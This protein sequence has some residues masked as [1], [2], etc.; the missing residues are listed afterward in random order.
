MILRSSALAMLGMIVLT[1]TLH[2]QSAVPSQ[3]S[4]AFN[5]LNLNRNGNSPASNYFQ[6]VRPQFQN[7]NALMNVQQ[8]YNNLQQS[9][10]NGDNS[11]ITMRGTGHAATFMSYGHYYPRMGGGTG[12]ASGAPSRSVGS[13]QRR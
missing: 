10:T 3:P 9:V 7:Q 5:W 12:G 6:L 8:E 1:T 11:S 13:G 4:S 2:A